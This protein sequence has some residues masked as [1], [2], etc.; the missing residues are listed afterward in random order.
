MMWDT[1]GQECYRSLPPFLYRSAHGA[2]VV[3]SI[4]SQKS[5]R[6]AQFWVEKLRREATPSMVIVLAGNKLDVVD[7]PSSSLVRTVQT[8]EACTY[9]EGEQLVALRDVSQNGRAGR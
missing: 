9:A 6:K 7:D 2:I 4:S 8:D 1:A 5:F 3:C